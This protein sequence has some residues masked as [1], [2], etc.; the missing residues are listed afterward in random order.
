[1]SEDLKIVGLL[2]NWCCYGGASIGSS[3]S[4]LQRTYKE[5]TGKTA[6]SNESAYKSWLT[7]YLAEKG[8]AN[9]EK[10]MS[11][12]QKKLDELNK[13]VPSGVGG[14]GGSSRKSAEEKAA[15]AF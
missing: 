11:E 8:Q 4:N 1:M 15:D 5:L 9:Y 2:C 3:S 6:Q 10:I 7:N 14:G 13:N 12:T